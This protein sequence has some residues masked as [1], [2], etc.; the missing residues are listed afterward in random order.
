AS[1]ARILLEPELPGLPD[2]ES[3]NPRRETRDDVT[4]ET[5]EITDVGDT[6][7]RKNPDEAATPDEFGDL[8]AMRFGGGR[9]RARSWGK[10]LTPQERARRELAARERVAKRLKAADA[11]SSI[12]ARSLALRSALLFLALVSGFLFLVSYFKPKKKTEEEEQEEAEELGPVSNQGITLDVSLDTSRSRDALLLEYHQL[13]A[14]LKRTRNHRR[15]PQTPVEHGDEH[16]G[17]TENLDD[18]LQSL[19]ETLYDSLYGEKEPSDSELEQAR[20]DCREIRSQ[21]G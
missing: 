18:A 11:Q 9:S 6:E 10:G 16:E 21:L 12:S 17:H 15:P 20:R 13:Q 2:F 19:S 5:P 8:F 4:P 7:T 3:K 14:D 1:R